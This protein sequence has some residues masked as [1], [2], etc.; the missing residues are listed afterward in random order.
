M[1]SLTQFQSD[2]YLIYETSRSNHNKNSNKRLLFNCQF[3]FDKQGITKCRVENQDP[4][5]ALITSKTPCHDFNNLNMRD[6]KLPIE[7]DLYFFFRKP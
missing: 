5:V 4:E 7:I 1:H 2:I 6:F 3:V